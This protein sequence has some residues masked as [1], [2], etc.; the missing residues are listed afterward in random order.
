[1]TGQLVPF[2]FNGQPIRSITVDGEPWFIATDVCS[3]LEIGNSRQA[4]SY[5]DDDEKGVT[6]NDTPGG[7]QQVGIV[8]ES[9][10]YS[11]IL[12]SRKAEA[13]AFK[14]WVTSVLLPQ[15][16][17]T[18]AYGQ[19]TMSREELLSRAVLEATSA[20]A[21]LEPKAKAFD[22]FLSSVGDYSV[23]EAAKVLSRDHGILTG[24]GRL[25]Q[26]ME[27]LGWI[28]RD[29]KNRPLPYQTQVDNGR[30]VAKPQFH[31]HPE[32]GDVVADPPQIRVTA[33]GLDALRGKYLDSK[34]A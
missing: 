20:I 3:I 28:Y 26:F 13:K 6:T 5:L 33:K 22:T 29:A 30:L 17:K 8:N 7:A 19:P 15:I 9:G 1:M 11:L 27:T 10:L 18:G 25:F 32:T 23:N 24:Q 4:V 12:R 14:K 2:D 21:E 31:Y 34:S 16:R